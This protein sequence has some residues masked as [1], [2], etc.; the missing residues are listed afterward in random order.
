V[1]YPYGVERWSSGT[2]PTDYRF[3]GQRF[4]AGLGIYVMGVRWYDSSLAWWLSADTL[5]PD[6][7][8]PQ[9]LN[10]YSYT[11]GNPVRFTDP[12]G[13]Y[14]KDEIMK[15][16]GV[17]SWDEVL[18]LFQKGGELEGLWGWL[19]ILRQA[20]DSDM[21]MFGAFQSTAT[22]GVSI[23][24]MPGNMGFFSRDEAGHILVNNKAASEFATKGQDY[25]YSLFREGDDAI[26]TLHYSTPSTWGHHHIHWEKVPS[27]LSAAGSN[28]LDVGY[29]LAAVAL[30][31]TLLPP[32]EAGAFAIEVLAWYKDW[33]PG[34][35]GAL[36]VAAYYEGSVGYYNSGNLFDAGGAIPA[37]GAVP[38]AAN[39]LFNFFG[40]RFYVTH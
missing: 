34:V 19:E 29:D 28:L 39:C 12:T 17:K 20:N 22:D 30:A 4:E 8:D 13:F 36:Q 40:W 31:A 10:R 25:I 38:D 37:L 24:S 1:G 14:S 16:F 27:D 5:V 7:N 3:T 21:V 9:S 33:E 26:Y 35:K 11:M 15:A 18:A 32:A 6:P 23:G 2:L